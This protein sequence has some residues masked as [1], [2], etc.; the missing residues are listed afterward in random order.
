[1]SERSDRRIVSQQFLLEDNFSKVRRVIDTDHARLNSCWLVALEEATRS[2][3]R[4]FVER[5]K[6]QL[7][8]HGDRWDGVCVFFN[9]STLNRQTVIYV[10][11]EH[12]R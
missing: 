11:W 7:D 2:V 10:S 9:S 3:R 5:I 8:P 6:R 1:M 4:L 12:F